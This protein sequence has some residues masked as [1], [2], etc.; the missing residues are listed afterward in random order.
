MLG[1]NFHLIP[2][3]RN[4][5][6]AMTGVR[7]RPQACTQSWTGQGLDAEGGNPENQ[8]GHHIMDWL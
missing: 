4:W 2:Q 7:V 8:D 3:F 6:G 5:G 1:I